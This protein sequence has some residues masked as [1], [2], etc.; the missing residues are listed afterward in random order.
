MGRRNYSVFFIYKKGL[1]IVRAN[2]RIKLPL[3]RTYKAQRYPV[4]SVRYNCTVLK[5]ITL[6]FSGQKYFQTETFFFTWTLSV[7]ATEDVGIS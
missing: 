6:E 2:Q 5:R 1:K 4:F 3:Q 7:E